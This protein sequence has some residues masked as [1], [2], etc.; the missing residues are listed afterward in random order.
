MNVMFSQ[1]KIL[2]TQSCF[3]LQ[4]NRKEQKPDIHVAQKDVVIETYLI[5]AT[6]HPKK[7]LKW[8]SSKHR[9]K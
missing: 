5:T 1:K 8:K 4:G 6:A 9:P 3:D 7:T 2:C